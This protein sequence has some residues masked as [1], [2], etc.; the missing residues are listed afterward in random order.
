MGSLIVMLIK[1]TD[2]TPMVK[3]SELDYKISN[4]FYILNKTIFSEGLSRDERAR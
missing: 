1:I 3:G 2:G 4:P